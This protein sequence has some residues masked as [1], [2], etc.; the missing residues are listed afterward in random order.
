M[1]AARRYQTTTPHATPKSRALARRC[2]PDRKRSSD[3][4]DCCFLYTERE[5]TENNE[6]Q[7]GRLHAVDPLLVDMEFVGK[8]SH[9]KFGA[10]R[11]LA[12][13]ERLIIRAVAV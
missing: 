4:V 6:E 10:R 12:R 11:S 13:P 3:I 5:A 1:A 8:A 2:L 7:H 9:G